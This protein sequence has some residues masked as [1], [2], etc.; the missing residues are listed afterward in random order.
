MYE[1]IGA[2]ITLGT[3]VLLYRGWRSERRQVEL[4]LKD[5]AKIAKINRQLGQIVSVHGCAPSDTVYKAGD[6]H[7][8]DACGTTWTAE[9]FRVD[10]LDESSLKN[11][12]AQSWHLSAQETLS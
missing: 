10:W 1:A 8:C 5:F 9:E 6:T 12:I 11:R 2:G 7:T 4:L 3:L